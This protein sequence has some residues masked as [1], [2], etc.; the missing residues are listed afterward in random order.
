MIS[1]D[2]Y[3]FNEKVHIKNEDCHIS[4]CKSFCDLTVK[5]CLMHRV[6]NNLQSFCENLFDNQVENRKALLTSVIDFGKNIHEE[7]MDQL[8]YCISPVFYDNSDVSIAANQSL[9]N[10]LKNLLKK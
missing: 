6:N 3:F 2:S 10:S 4:D 1:S 5:K 8:D 7:L 9:V